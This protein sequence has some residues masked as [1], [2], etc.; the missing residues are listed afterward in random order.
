[1]LPLSHQLLPSSCSNPQEHHI[2]NVSMFSVLLPLPELLLPQD[3]LGQASL[4]DQLRNMNSLKVLSSSQPG[5]TLLF[6]E[7]WKVQNKA[8]DWNTAQRAHCVCRVSV[9]ESHEQSA[10]SWTRPKVN[11]KSHLPTCCSR[12]HFLF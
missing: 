2:L 11:I 9:A 5:W 12:T 10:R 7:G 6:K 4:C 1:M 3:T 8:K